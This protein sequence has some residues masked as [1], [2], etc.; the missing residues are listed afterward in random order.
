MRAILWTFFFKF[1]QNICDLCE[2][3]N[4]R[5]LFHS[6]G[7]SFNNRSFF[8]SVFFRIIISFVALMCLYFCLVQSLV[9]YTLSCQIIVLSRLHLNEFVNYSTIFWTAFTFITPTKCAILPRVYFIC[10]F[11]AIFILQNRQ[12]LTF[13]CFTK[14]RSFFSLFFLL[15]FSIFFL[16]YTLPSLSTEVIIEK[17]DFS[18]FLKS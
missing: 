14:C 13:F 17:W 12:T 15:I 7:K 18:R 5:L 8:C 2:R 3:K 4:S 9:H 16:F 10:F 1:F 6:N 11:I